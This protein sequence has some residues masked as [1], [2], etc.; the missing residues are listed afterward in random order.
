MHKAEQVLNN[1]Y[2]AQ[3]T[4]KEINIAQGVLESFCLVMYLVSSMRYHYANP[5]VLLLFLLLGASWVASTSDCGSLV[6]YRQYSDL[7][8]QNDTACFR[9]GC[10]SATSIS[11]QCPEESPCF[12]LWDVLR[13]QFQP[14]WCASCPEDTACRIRG[15]PVL[16][17]TAA[18]AAVPHEWLFGAQ[19]GCCASDSEPFLLSDWI[20]RLCNG[21]QWRAPFEYY[22]GMAKKDWEE[23][24][25][26]LNWTLTARN[27]STTS[28]QKQSCSSIQILTS[29]LIENA[30]ELVAFLIGTGFTI[31]QAGRRGSEF[32]EHY[33]IF[34]ILGGVASAAVWL[35]SN[36]ITSLVISKIHGYQGAPRA[37]LMLLFCTRPNFILL[38]CGLGLFIHRFEEDELPERVS[39]RRRMNYRTNKVRLYLASVVLA[40]TVAAA[41]IQ[42][43]G[44]MY[45]FRAAQ[46]GNM[47]G[48]YHAHNLTPYWRGSSAQTMYA[49]ALLWTIFYFITL[50]LL[51]VLG[52]LMWEKM[53]NEASDRGHRRS[54]RVYQW[55]TN[56]MVERL[57]VLNANHHHLALNQELVFSS[58]G[59]RR[60]RFIRLVRSIWLAILSL[61][62]VFYEQWPAII[63]NPRSDKERLVHRSDLED[64]EKC[65]RRLRLHR[66]YEKAN[67]ADPRETDLAEDVRRG[68]SFLVVLLWPITY[69]SQW[70]FWSGFVESM[71]DR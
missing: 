26:P 62:V 16:N 48:F 65:F 34:A 47:K 11:S 6:T 8:S 30:V 14:D 51:F 5:A 71:G 35:V 66:L 4:S 40:T 70:L 17:A 9:D 19:G 44:S 46:T 61:H 52:Y 67:N 10:G 36:Y 58:S 3:A 2:K 57:A 22:G 59:R 15:W 24:I 68:F 38:F 64:L 12:V 20:E 60:L 7:L 63:Y 56:V 41:L 32:K 29:F 45:M 42:T 31:L 55:F 27:T 13:A 43:L 37:D 28:V 1:N 23:W 53:Q 21:S 54:N 49:G 25:E 50:I 33:R 39:R 18:C 69:T